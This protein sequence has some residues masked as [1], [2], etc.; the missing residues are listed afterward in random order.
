M[1]NKK[2]KLLLLDIE[3]APHQ[4]FIWNMWDKFVPLDRLKE[5]GR[6]LCW[7]A[8]WFDK[9]RL[10]YMDERRG[11]DR[12]VKGIH[13]LMSE[14]DV[15]I[16]YNGSKFDIPMLNN[17]FV[18]YGLDPIKPQKHIDLYKTAKSQFKLPSN[19]L[20]YIAEYLGVGQ[21]VPHKGFKLWLGCLAG[22][23]EDWATMKEYNMGDVVL[24]ESVYRRLRPWVK[25]HP[26]VAV[27]L[28][29]E[30]CGSCGSEDVQRR[31]C[32]RTK[33]FSI[34]RLHCQECGAWTDG[35]KKKI[36]P[37]KAAK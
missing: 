2:L 15:I 34:V 32:R 11:A 33:A 22:N 17:E 16:T 7:A 20:S 10:Y 12:M 1:T 8:K 25:N 14:A 4:A 13:A 19:K 3:T 27:E 6:T 31:G 23:K 9:G 37:V 5:Q 28:V 30:H 26:D 24:L 35:T 21:K 36:P 29:T 18:K